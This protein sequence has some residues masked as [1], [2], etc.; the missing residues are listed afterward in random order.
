MVSDE[1]TP[2]TFGLGWLNNSM[3]I[4]AEWLHYPEHAAAKTVKGFYFFNPQTAFPTENSAAITLRLIPEGSAEI[5]GIFNPVYLG[6]ISGNYYYWNNGYIYKIRTSEI[7]STSSQY[8]MK[9]EYTID[10]AE[11]ISSSSSLNYDDV[12]VRSL[13]FK[14]IYDNASSQIYLLFYQGG[15]ES[16]PTYH[17]YDFSKTNPTKR[18]KPI[19]SMFEGLT[20]DNPL[21]RPGKQDLKVVQIGNSIYFPASRCQ[22]ECRTP[23]FPNF[24]NVKNSTD[25]IK[26]NVRLL[27]SN[28]GGGLDDG[29][30]GNQMGGI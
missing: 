12:E 4:A 10:F 24:A 8:M 23:L 15:T 22:T 16:A 26:V 11:R 21:S 30:A 19:N 28:Y 18:N 25:L 9:W 20:V 29:N 27:P 7:S 2:S 13:K 17:I 6:F 14:Q 5:S 1:K 3:L